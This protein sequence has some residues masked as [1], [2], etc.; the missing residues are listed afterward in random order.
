MIC[1]NS[2]HVFLIKSNVFV[3]YISQLPT[4]DQGTDDH[5]NRNDKLSGNKGFT[6]K[7]DIGLPLYFAFQDFNRI[8]LRKNKSRVYSGYNSD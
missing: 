7:S 3:L 6:E 1:R 5:R 2:Y 4:Y 8:E